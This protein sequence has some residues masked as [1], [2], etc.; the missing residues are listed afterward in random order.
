VTTSV[1]VVEASIT[2]LAEALACGR[3][4]AVGLL[5]ITDGSIHDL[6]SASQSSKGDFH[7]HLLET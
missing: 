1:D 7:E 3:V 4:S 6:D 5:E 2:D